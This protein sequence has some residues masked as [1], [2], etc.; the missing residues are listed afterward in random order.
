MGDRP[1]FL[2]QRESRRESSQKETPDGE[3]KWLAVP[4]KWRVYVGESRG[5]Q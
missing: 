1:L 5:G 2:Y 3:K 4:A